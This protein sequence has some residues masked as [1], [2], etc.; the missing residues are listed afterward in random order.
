MSTQMPAPVEDAALDAV[1]AVLAHPV[2]RRL[3]DLLVEGE[4]PVNALAAPFAMSRPAVSQHLHAL[5][6]AGLVAEHR[7]GRERRYRLQPERLRLVREWLR[8]YERFWR[9]HLVALADYLEGEQ[10]P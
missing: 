1:L 8:T 9:D 4:R 7:A 3:L 6:K 5:L 10:A 2:R